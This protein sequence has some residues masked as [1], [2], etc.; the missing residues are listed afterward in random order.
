MYNNHYH[1]YLASVIVRQQPSVLLKKCW[2]GA[3]NLPS[4]METGLTTPV[5]QRSNYSNKN[6]T[7][8]SIQCNWFNTIM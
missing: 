3:T 5:S 7:N 6:Q 1:N 4:L 8:C 2:P